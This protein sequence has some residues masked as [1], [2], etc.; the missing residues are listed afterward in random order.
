M[1]YD[2]RRTRA[3]TDGGEGNN[4]DDDDDDDEEKVSRDKTLTRRRF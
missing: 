2:K 3:D 4:G 1:Q